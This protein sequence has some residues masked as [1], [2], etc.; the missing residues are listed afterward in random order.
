MNT[1]VLVDGRL[2]RAERAKRYEALAK[3]AEELG[4]P[5]IVDDIR[6]ISSIWDEDSAVVETAPE[7]ALRVAGSQDGHH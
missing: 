4:D 2:F 5:S 3:K 1:K 6:K 7:V